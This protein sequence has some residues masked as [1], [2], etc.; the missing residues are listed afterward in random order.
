MVPFKPNQRTFHTATLVNNKLYILDGIS[1]NLTRTL[2]DFFYLDVSATYNTQNLPWV[3]LSSINTIVPQHAAATSVK[4][5]TNNNTLILYGG[6][7]ANPKSSSLY[8]FDTQ[9]NSWNIP[10]IVGNI[11]RKQSLT[12]IIDNNGKMYLWGGSDGTNEL[13]DMFILDTINLIERVGSLVGAPTPRYNYGATLLPDNN[14]IY[15]GGY[16]GNAEFPLDLVYIYNTMNN[17]WSNITAKGKVPFSRDGFSVILGLDGS[18]VIIFGG[19]STYSI[20][21]LAPDDSIYELNLFNFEWIIPKISNTSQ[22][23]NSRMY[24]KANVIGKYMIISFGLGYDPSIESDILL[25]DISNKNEY[26]W[27]D[28]F[29]LN[30]SSISTK[31]TATNTVQP[32]TSTQPAQYKNIIGIII[33]SLICITLVSFGGFFL[34]KWNKKTKWQKYIASIPHILSDC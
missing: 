22:I 21:G 29:D 25:L 10:T 33:G 27:T 7:T 17:S 34:Y 30:S 18:S 5:G 20:Q 12:G 28:A 2:N 16:D 19:T 11:P 6:V 14:I 13:N 24:H 23:P 26:V 8:T 31:P 3:D 32:E 15:M 1:I 4:G 9:T